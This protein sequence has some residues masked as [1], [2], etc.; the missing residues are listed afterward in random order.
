[1]V[2]SKDEATGWVGRLRSIRR[3]VETSFEDAATIRLNGVGTAANEKVLIS[4][5]IDA[6][7]MVEGRMGGVSDR[8]ERSVGGTARLARCCPAI[9]SNFWWVQCALYHSRWYRLSL[10][11]LQQWLK[12]NRTAAG[13]AGCSATSTNS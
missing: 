13:S 3:R 9:A 11:P 12:V 10:S 2:G 5:A 7:K 1:M 4:A 6:M 8:Q